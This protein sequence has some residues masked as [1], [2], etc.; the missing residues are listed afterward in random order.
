VRDRDG[1]GAIHDEMNRRLLPF[2]FEPESRP[3]SAHL[4]LARVKDAP[5]G[6]GRAVR[7]ALA[8]RDVSA[9]PVRVTAATLFQSH[10]SP[11]GPRYEAVADIP[12]R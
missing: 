5:R 10:L 7:D 12:L 9:P 2:G 1:L 6:S 11:H 3:F 8:G 4:T